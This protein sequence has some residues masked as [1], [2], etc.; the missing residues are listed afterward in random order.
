M[1]DMR[2]LPSDNEND[3]IQRLRHL[4]STMNYG[5]SSEFIQVIPYDDVR[6]GIGA[7]VA[8]LS[9]VPDN[10]ASTAVIFCGGSNWCIR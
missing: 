4:S 3:I 10:K 8:Y 1:L 5:F 7:A 6:E 2:E 9:S